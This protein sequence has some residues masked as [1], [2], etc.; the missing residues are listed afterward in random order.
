MT[1]HRRLGPDLIIIPT[2]ELT[3]AHRE[4]IL[5]LIQKGAAI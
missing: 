4:A 5:E 2:D 1:I 3:D